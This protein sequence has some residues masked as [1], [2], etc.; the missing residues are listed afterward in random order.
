M[1]I[2][3]GSLF[4]LG[5][6]LSAS[7][8]EKVPDLLSAPTE[9]HAQKATSERIVG[10]RNSQPKLTRTGEDTYEFGYCAGIGSA[11]GYPQNYVVEAAI[12]IPSYMSKG[13]EGMEITKVFIGFGTSKNRNVNLY[14]TGDLDGVPYYMQEAAMEKDAIV[15]SENGAVEEILQVWNEVELDTPYKIDGNPFYLGYQA[16]CSAAPCYP[17]GIDLIYTEDKLG[18]IFGASDG[19]NGEMRYYNIGTE[20]GS[21]CIRFEMK[22][23]MTAQYEAHIGSLLLDN[24]VI[25]QNEEFNAAFTLLN[26]GA[27]TITDLDMTCT[28][29]GIEVEDLDFTLYGTQIGEIPFGTLGYVEVKGKPGK[30]SG[31][32]LPLEISINSLV[33]ENGRG[34]FNSTISTPISVVSSLFPKKF[35]VEEFTGTWCQWCP[36]G[37]VGMEF[38][39]ENY[40]DKGFIGIAV[41]SGDDPM[42]AS[43][44]TNMDIYY[45]GGSYPSAVANRSEYFDPSVETLV[46]YYESMIESGAIAKVEIDALYDEEENEIN[47]T[48]TTEFTDDNPDANYAFSFVVTQDNVGPYY[49]QNAFAGGANGQ[50]AGWEKEGRRVLT[51]YNMVARYIDGDFGIY[52]SLPDVIEGGKEYSYSVRLSVDEIENNSREFIPLDINN[53]HVI[54]LLID[55]NTGVILNA[56]QMS[57]KGQA[58]VESLMSEHEKG[59]YKVYNLQGV[60]LLETLNSSDIINLPA[61]IYIINGKKVVVR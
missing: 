7:A 37:L 27:Q 46:S 39:K 55:L 43:S 38:M 11:L 61:G 58:G 6:F 5:A 3:I 4:Y 52:G 10:G 56:E 26:L 19:N 48:A 40:S 47:V 9:I 23:E 8:V 14:I 24:N 49:Q 30:I 32:D 29:G 35:V 34:E 36:R 60:K 31:I 13:W 22:G 59:T 18:D 28:I 21:V 25:K 2:V 16:I 1:K 57:L 20:Y 42:T 12:E 54:A 17:V 15:F 44:Y 50:L 45:S 41:H 53:T 33:G 51:E